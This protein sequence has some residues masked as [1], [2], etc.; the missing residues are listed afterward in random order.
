MSRY[1]VAD[2]KAG[3]PRL[4]D[5]AMAG[6]EVII[7]RHGTLPSSKPKSDR[8]KRTRTRST[9]REVKR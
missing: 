9:P 4:I 5:K 6:E 3:L 8:S 1:G 7:T 2:A